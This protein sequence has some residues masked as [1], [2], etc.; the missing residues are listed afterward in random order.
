M[1]EAGEKGASIAQPV[2]GHSIKDHVGFAGAIRFER[3]MGH[4]QKPRGAGIGPGDVPHLWRKPDERRNRFIQW[5]LKFRKG[6][7]EARPSALR[8]VL[9]RPAGQALE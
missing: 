2:Q 3:S 5:P 7:A 1:I 4:T 6:G 8:L 9:V